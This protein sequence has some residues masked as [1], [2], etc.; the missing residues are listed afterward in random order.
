MNEKTDNAVTGNEAGAYRP[1]L[2]FYHA[3]GKGTG[4]AARFELHPA[5]GDTEGSVWVT[6]A[7]QLTIGD[8]RGPNPVYPRFDWE[9]RISVR[10]CFGDL[11]KML[12]V[13]RGECEAIDD[14]RGLYH[15]SARANTKILLRHLV[16]TVQGYSLE[17]F[18]TSLGDKEES[19]AHILLTPAEALGL[20][21]A[22]ESSFGVI[23]F[24]IPQVIEHDTTAYRAAR[25]E[26][27]DASAA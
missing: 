6:L 18:R 22:V 26:A 3:N 4:C 10:L 25:K 21:A 7:N 23:C 11:T 20:A 1:R 24:G 5:H 19:H 9:G 8:R 2:T 27:R 14:G 12:Q 17:V 16:E 13:F 15:A